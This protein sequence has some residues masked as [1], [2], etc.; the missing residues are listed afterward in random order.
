MTVTVGASFTGLTMIGTESVSVSGPPGPE[1]PKSLLVTTSASLPLKF[2]FGRYC[3]PF[4]A[5]LID[6]SVPSATIVGSCVPSPVRNVR[7]EVVESVNVPRATLSVM[8]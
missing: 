1:F 4:K 6:G 7:P 3:K 8:R 5:L 2:R